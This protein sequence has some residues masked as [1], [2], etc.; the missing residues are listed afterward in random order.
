M[1]VYWLQINYK[2]GI[3]M[4]VEA[5]DWN[6]KDTK[7]SLTI[8]GEGQRCVVLGAEYIESIWQLSVREVAEVTE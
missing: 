2:S 3:T 4:Q 6:L 5:S 7:I 8:Y 1:K